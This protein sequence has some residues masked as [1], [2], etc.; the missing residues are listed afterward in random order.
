MDPDGMMAIEN[1][2]QCICDESGGASTSGPDDDF[3]L[4][5]DG[6]LTLIK[7]TEDQFHRYLNEDG[8]VIWQTNWTKEEVGNQIASIDSP[9]PA[10]DFMDNLY[11]LL[12][13]FGNDGLN[14]NI[15]LT[16]SERA[17]VEGWDPHAITE[18]IINSQTARDKDLTDFVNS[19]FA[20]NNH[21]RGKMPV[22]GPLR[23]GF[24]LLTGVEIENVGAW[25][26]RKLQDG[27]SFDWNNPKHLNRLDKH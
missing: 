11:S 15:I 2:K 17:K 3:R 24:L 13:A 21:I 18:L 25:F 12:R 5:N 7:Q 23:Q 8:T 1:G 9:T 22:R 27:E 26:L 16:M 19:F 6:S 20:V 14:K 10:K 4:N